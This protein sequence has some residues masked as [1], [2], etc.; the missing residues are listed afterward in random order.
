MD[1][2][3]GFRATAIHAAG[4]LAPNG[5]LYRLTKI[6]I[7]NTNMAEELRGFYAWGWGGS[8]LVSRG[9]EEGLGV[10]N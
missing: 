8:R 2:E 9:G 5:T 10:R 3:T 4:P 7:G 6:D 1:P